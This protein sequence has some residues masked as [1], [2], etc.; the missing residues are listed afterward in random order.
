MPK[1]EL[2][3]GKPREGCRAVARGAKA[4]SPPNFFSTRIRPPEPSVLAGIAAIML[5]ASIGAAWSPIGRM[6]TVDLQ[7]L[8]RSE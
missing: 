1:R 5:A 7:R 2:R 8:L 6:L 4:T 3:L